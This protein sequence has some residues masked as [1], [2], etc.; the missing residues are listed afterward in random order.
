MYI[1]CSMNNNIEQA[2][3]AAMLCMLLCILVLYWFECVYK[4]K[5][6]LIKFFVLLH[7]DC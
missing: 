2:D 1:D 5:H 4:T 3:L 6:K 7:C